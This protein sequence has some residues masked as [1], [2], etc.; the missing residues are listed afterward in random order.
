MKAEGAYLVICRGDDL[1]TSG[2]VIITALELEQRED[3]EDGA[4]RVH[5]KDGA[6]G[7]YVADADIKIFDS[8]GGEPS[9]GRTD[10]RGVFQASGI[11]GHATVVVRH[12]DTRYA[13]FR[14]MEPMRPQTR[15][16]SSPAQPGQAPAA[17]GKPMSK[18]DYLLNVKMQL[19]GNQMENKSSW[20][21][22]VS[23]GGK[24]V[25]VE[26]ALKK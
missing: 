7:G 21:E 25:E 26:K 14:S 1:S 16:P 13:F 9:S 18:E 3:R 8:A 23:K 12:G 2:L 4:L 11:T 6:K 24:G 22:K 15:K 5:V 17:K 20:G 19:K 10:P